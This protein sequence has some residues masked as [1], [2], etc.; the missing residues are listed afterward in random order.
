MTA[1]NATVATNGNDGGKVHED[2]KIERTWMGVANGYMDIA[3]RAG[4]GKMGPQEAKAATHA[5]DGVPKILKT[6]LEVLKFYEKSSDKAREQAA[7]LLEMTAPK[8]LENKPN[9]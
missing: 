8:A 9:N 6:H 1:L 3:E 5:L 4:S 7:S 2:L